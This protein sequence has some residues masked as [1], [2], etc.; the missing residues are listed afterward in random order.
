MAR[1]GSGWLRLARVLQNIAK[2][3]L[4]KTPLGRVLTRPIPREKKQKGDPVQFAI[5]PKE[6]HQVVVIQVILLQIYII[7]G[8]F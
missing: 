6:L 4:G 5:N 3:G 7:C 2:V 1:V 8:T